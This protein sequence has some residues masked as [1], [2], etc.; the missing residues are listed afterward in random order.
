VDL[1]G[2]VP[3][4]LD[5][6]PVGRIVEFLDRVREFLQA[7]LVVVPDLLLRPVGG[8]VGLGRAPCVLA[9]LA[10]VMGA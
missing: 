3:G 7:L 5:Q 4:L 10:R 1:V 9:P 6:L 2:E 8:G